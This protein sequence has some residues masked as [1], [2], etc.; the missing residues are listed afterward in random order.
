[1]SWYTVIHLTHFF[2][3]ELDLK[4]RQTQEKESMRETDTQ[5]RLE[6]LMKEKD[7]LIDLSMQRGKMI[8]VSNETDFTRVTIRPLFPGHVQNF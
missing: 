2:P 1:M 7:E 5:E 6:K 8:L 3:T 4:L